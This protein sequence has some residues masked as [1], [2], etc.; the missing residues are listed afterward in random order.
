MKEAP[1]SDMAKA[2]GNVA[3]G[4]AD[5]FQIALRSTDFQKH[6]LRHRY[7]LPAATAAAV[8]ELAFARSDT[9]RDAR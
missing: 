5:T 2:S 4:T 8:A 7:G 1:A 9:W 3:V 6:H